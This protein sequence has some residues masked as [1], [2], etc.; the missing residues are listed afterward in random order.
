[1]V[2]HYFRKFGDG[3][4]EGSIFH[5]TMSS[6]TSFKQVRYNIYQQ[7][8]TVAPEDFYSRNGWGRIILYIF[9]MGSGC[10]NVTPLSVSS[11]EKIFLKIIQRKLISIIILMI[12]KSTINC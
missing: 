7:K 12:Q 9:L 1:M 4:T 10:T 3:T 5:G 8:H 6:G 2:I 11:N